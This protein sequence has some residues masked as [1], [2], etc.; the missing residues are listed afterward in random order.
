M[1]ENFKIWKKLY[2]SIADYRKKHFIRMLILYLRNYV[3]TNVEQMKVIL[4]QLYDVIKQKKTILHKSFT[5]NIEKNNLKE[6]IKHNRFIS[7]A[8]IKDI[9]T[10]GYCT[11]IEAKYKDVIIKILIT[12]VDRNECKVDIPKVLNIIRIFI[13]LYSN[14]HKKI[15]INFHPTPLKK[16]FPKRDANM[17]SMEQINSGSTWFRNNE[18]YQM[19]L[20]R[21]EELYKVLIHEL[22]HYFKNDECQH[23]YTLPN[24]HTMY[25]ICHDSEV[26]S[27][28]AITETNAIIIHH[29]LKSIELYD[30]EEQVWKCFKLML[31]LD[32]V[33]AIYQSSQILKFYGFSSMNEFIG[34]PTNKC[35]KQDTSVFSYYILKSL[36]LFNI[37]NFLLAWKNNKITNKVIDLMN[38]SISSRYHELL[39]QFHKYSYSNIT[40]CMSCLT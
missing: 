35:L 27:K 39:Q 11:N 28:E 40:L 9:L 4:K 37:H 6:M 25:K 12:H 38:K 21:S 26:R 5:T 16:V 34:K 17:I 15:N 20:F 32:T 8:M 18:A 13:D 7:E 10:H 1:I 29:L 14:E 36:F 30:N 24:F 31:G 22:C 3:D 2:H 33:H 19:F 23:E